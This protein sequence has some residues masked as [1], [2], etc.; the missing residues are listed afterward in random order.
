MTG[1]LIERYMTFLTAIIYWL[2]VLF[3]LAIVI[4][5]ARQYGRFKRIYP[6][7]TVLLIVLLIDGARTLIES[8]YF[9]VWYT[10]RT[11]LIAP[12]LHALLAEPYYVAI[13]KT[14]NLFAALIIILVIV[15][16]WFDSLE[17]EEHQRQATA[18][19][20]EELISLASHELR[21]PLTSIR[22]YAQTL[23]RE[24]DHLGPDTRK[25]FLDVIAVESERLT[26]LISDLLDMS[27]IEEGRLRIERRAMRPDDLCRE[28]VT[29]ATYPGLKREFRTEVAPELPDV[30]ADS[31]RIQQALANLLSNAV[32][33]SPEDS[34]IVVGARAADGAVQFYV[35]DHGVGIPREDQGRLFT[36]F[37]R[38]SE[39]PAP[40]TPGAGLGLYITRAVVE[41][42]EGTVGFESELGKGSTFYFT[43]PTVE[44][45][46][47]AEARGGE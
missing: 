22:G 29:R 39:P 28:A 10:A 30:L 44:S 16:R 43:L 5:Y 25:E 21:A 18:K 13:P 19:F 34:E 32:K 46:V 12:R 41:A 37:H 14:I 9:G 24:F 17:R 47:E 8:V 6:L 33:F 23:A 2:L 11:G 40:E 27:Q 35:T 36:R 3:W 7:L 38:G 4:F 31:E 45:K 42:H 26:H 20:R 1:L 15:R